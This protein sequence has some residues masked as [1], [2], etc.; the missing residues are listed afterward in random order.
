MLTPAPAPQ[1]TPLLTPTPAPASGAAL[2]QRPAD[3]PSQHLALVVPR[4][5]YRAAANAAAAAAPCGL[6]ATSA[7]DAGLTLLGVVERSQAAAVRAALSAGNIPAG[8]PAARIAL[9]PFDGPYCP[10]LPLLRSVLAGPADAPQVAVDGAMPLRRGDLLRFGVTMPSWPAHLYVAYFMKSG[11]VAH[12]VPS[13]QHPANARVRLG[14]PAPG[15]PGWEIDE[16]FGTDLMVVVASERPLFPGLRPFVEPQEAYLE[17]LAAA[18]DGARRQGSRVAVR[19][20]VI[21]TVAR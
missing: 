12:L 16:P 1:P 2:L 14:D 8:D 17:A 11:E 6:I 3:P 15:F 21:E 4:L 19:P 18:L 9:Q 20:V 13:A 7:T 10:A 5:D